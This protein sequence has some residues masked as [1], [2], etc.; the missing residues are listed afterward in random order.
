MRAVLYYLGCHTQGGVMSAVLLM[1]P[2]PSPAFHVC[3]RLRPFLSIFGACCSPGSLCIIG[4]IRGRSAS[5]TVPIF[6]YWLLPALLPLWRGPLS[7]PFVPLAMSN[8]LSPRNPNPF[9][10]ALKNLPKPT[11]GRTGTSLHLR[12]PNRGV[13]KRGLVQPSRR[14]TCHHRRG[15]LVDGG[16]TCIAPW[17]VLLIAHE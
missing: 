17:L 4:G 12:W 7:A 1:S 3:Y 13:P 8:T 10:L 9:C 15:G 2:R 11:P 6:F 16:A 14:A 5:A